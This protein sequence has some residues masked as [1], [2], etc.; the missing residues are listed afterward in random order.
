[1]LSSCEE[2]WK[3][4]HRSKSSIHTLVITI[5]TEVA[6]NLQEILCHPN[7]TS[8][9]G[10]NKNSQYNSEVFP[11]ELFFFPSEGKKQLTTFINC[12][13]KEHTPKINYSEEFASSNGNGGNTQ[14]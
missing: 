11:H 2:A 9:F 8:G 12:N 4:E 6:K 13:T 1:M 7:Q 10:R 3:G 5:Y 14:G